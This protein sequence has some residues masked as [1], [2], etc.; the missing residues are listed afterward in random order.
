VVPRGT[1]RGNGKVETVDSIRTKEGYGRE[2]VSERI[3]TLR[4]KKRITREIDYKTHLF[5]GKI[6]RSRILT[7]IRNSPVNINQGLPRKERI[8]M[9]I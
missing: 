2:E 3:E 5:K 7:V 1:K 9:A 4:M 8:S 6:Y